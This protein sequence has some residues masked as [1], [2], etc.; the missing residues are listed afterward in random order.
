V[1]GSVVSPD[2]V[3]DIRI[4]DVLDLIVEGM[5]VGHMPPKDIGGVV[6]IICIFLVG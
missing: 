2:E 3:T 4:P 6:S 1:G 5:R